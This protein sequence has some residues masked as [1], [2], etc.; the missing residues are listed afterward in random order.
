MVKNQ[1]KLEWQTFPR[2]I[3]IS[4][5]GWS[6]KNNKNFKSFQKRLTSFVPWL[7]L[8]KVNY[9]KKEEY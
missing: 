7:D 3:A 8:L 4:E 1:E 5:T 6:P 2:L 9:A